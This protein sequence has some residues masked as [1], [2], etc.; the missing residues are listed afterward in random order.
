MINT[1]KLREMARMQ[2]R[3]IGRNGRAVGWKR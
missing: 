3:G 2:R 1:T